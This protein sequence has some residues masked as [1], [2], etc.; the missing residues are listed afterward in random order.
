[1]R[2]NHTRNRLAKQTTGRGDFLEKTLRRA[3]RP[4]RMALRALDSVSDWKIAAPR[5][6]SGNTLSARHRQSGALQG[7]FYRPRR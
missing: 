7:V 1:M 4:K 5:D 6:S 3:A 2:G